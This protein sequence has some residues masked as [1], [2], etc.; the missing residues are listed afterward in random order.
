[1]SRR[2]SNRRLHAPRAPGHLIPFNRPCITGDEE[3]KLQE[4]LARGVFSGIGPFS[5]GCRSHLE[6]LL[7]APAVF[8]TSS[9]SA[10]LEMAAIL[11]DL[12]PEDEVILPSFAFPTTASAFARC[13]ARLVF[14]D[15]EPRTMNISPEAVRRALTS[16]TRVVVALHYAGVACDM[17][18]LGELAHKHNLIV[19]EDAAQ[20]IGASYQGR[21]CGTFGRFGCLSFHETKNLQ[22]GEG[23]ALIVNQPDDIERAEV[24][25]EKGTN[26]AGFFRGETDRYTWRELGSSFVLG[27]LNAAFLKAQLDHL[28]PI[29]DERIRTW[30]RYRE[31]LM[32]LSEQG[33]I[34]IPAIPDD[35]AHNGHIFWI[36]TR[37]MAARESLITALRAN[38]IHSVFHYLPLHKSPAGQRF[39][40]FSGHDRFTSEHSGRLLRLPIYHGFDAVDHVAD[41]VTAALWHGAKA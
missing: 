36:K 19:V 35:R 30:S 21:P 39:G 10:A 11:C 26:R 22:C 1:M 27:E 29:T 23:G 17:S 41:Q 3:A 32:P 25:L 2:F 33:L 6:S 18:F 38:G 12:K 40:R 37:D 34:D 5:E 9:C 31:R 28:A 20:C 7:G 14:V 24:V 8:P 16:R 4:V 13:G 15:I